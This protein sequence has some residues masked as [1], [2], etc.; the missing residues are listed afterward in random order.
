MTISPHP[1][2]LAVLCYVVDIVVSPRGS[3]GGASVSPYHQLLGSSCWPTAES[4]VAAGPPGV[5]RLATPHPDTGC[6]A[7]YYTH[8][9]LE[10]EYREVWTVRVANARL[11]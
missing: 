11:L 10:H 9:V 2:Y 5:D 6:D 7:Y 3:T 8:E 4:S 1:S